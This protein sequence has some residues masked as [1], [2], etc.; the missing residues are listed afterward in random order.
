MQRWCSSYFSSEGHVRRYSF[1]HSIISSFIHDSIKWCLTRNRNRVT[2]I[3]LLN[4]RD[5]V[6]CLS[7]WQNKFA[8]LN[9]ILTM[10]IMKTHECYKITFL[11]LLLHIWY[12]ISINVHAACTH[13]S[14]NA[15]MHTHKHIQS[16][17]IGKVYIKQ[18]SYKLVDARTYASM[19]MDVVYTLRHQCV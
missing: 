18:H 8:C 15:H 19:T 12:T 16:S 5:E 9:Y 4:N 7:C 13:S 14:P 3:K 6:L 11:L 10:L 1:V 2:W 17:N